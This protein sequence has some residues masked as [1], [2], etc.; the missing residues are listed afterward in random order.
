MENKFKDKQQ[1]IYKGRKISIFHIDFVKKHVEQMLSG[2]LNTREMLT[3]LNEEAI[4]SKETQ[5]KDAG[6]IKRIMIMIL[7]N[8]PEKMKKYKETLRHNTGSRSPYKGKIGNSKTGEYYLK[9]LKFKKRIIDEYLPKIISGEIT[10]EI[11]EKELNT[12]HHTFDKIVEEYYLKHDDTEGLKAYREAKKKNYGVSLEKR[13]NAKSMREE[14]EKYEVV[15][16]SEFLLLSEEEQEKQIVMK[17]RQSKLKEE[18]N[19]KS[20]RSVVITEET[21]I[22][23]I[24]KIKD[25]FKEKNDIDKGIEYFSEQDI[26][27]IIFRYPTII[28]RDYET[29]DEKLEV[30][31]SYDEIDEKTAYEMIKSFPAIMGYDAQRTKKQ[32]DLLNQESLIDYAIQRPNG[33]MRS[34]HLMH[35]LIQFAKERHQTEDLSN[36]NKSNIFMANSTLKR[37]YRVTYE[38]IKE[39]YQY[40]PLEV[41][42]D[43]P[44]SITGTDLGKA[45]YD[46]VSVEQSDE[47]ALIV[48]QLKSRGEGQKGVEN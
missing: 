46:N 6:T 35:A 22:A 31:K 11:I 20:I 25:Y 34:P 26:R 14:V 45:T 47:A 15:S 30:L 12:S 17:I 5:I 39:R 29:L 33:L 43:V 24:E 42:E 8:E 4:K 23:M 10:F 2:E 40:Q 18:K 48:Q 37:L 13:E 36:V 19:S 32:L 1:P 28:S 16:N 3:L 7:S 27:Y 41:E 44:Y 9:E 38:E 21:T